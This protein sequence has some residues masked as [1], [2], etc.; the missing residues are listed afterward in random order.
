[1]PGVCVC[2]VVVVCVCLLRH[3]QLQ[4]LK[5]SSEM[6]SFIICSIFENTL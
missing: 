6:I 5:I 2:F 3:L 1:M 4:Q